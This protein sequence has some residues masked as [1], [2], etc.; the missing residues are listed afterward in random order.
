[1]DKSGE[2]TKTVCVA[3]RIGRP[4][5]IKAHGPECR[6]LWSYFFRSDKNKFRLRIKKAQDQPASGC[7]IDSDVLASDPFHDRSPFSIQVRPA[8]RSC[9]GKLHSVL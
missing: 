4:G 3:V 9:L 1:M 5:S 2:G 8:V 6:L 7:A